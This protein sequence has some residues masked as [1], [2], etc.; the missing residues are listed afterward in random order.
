MGNETVLITGATGFVGGR[1]VERLALGTDY[2][3]KA[4]VRTFSGP[5]L[6]RIARLPV[7]LVLADLLDTES[8]IRAARSCDVVVHCAYGS[9][10]GK[11][12]RKEVT[13]SGTENVL[14]AALR[15]GVRKVIHLSSSAV[16]GRA[17]RGPVVDE[18]APFT[19]SHDLYSTSKIEAEKIVWRFQQEHG[20]PVIVFRPTIIYG[21]YG[22]MW[23]TRIVQEIQSGAILVNGGSGAANL[24]YV[25]NLVDAI[26]LAMQKD[27]GDGEAF[28]LVDDEQLSWQDVYKG[29]ADI[30]NACPPLRGLSVQE[31]EAQRKAEKPSAFD[32]WVGGPW[33]IAWEL[34]RYALQPPEARRRIRQIPWMRLVTRLVPERIKDRIRS[35]D[36]GS[37]TALADTPR[38]RSLRLPGKE[39]VELYA[40]QSRFS[41]EKAK[42]ILG[43]TQ[44]V[45]FD[46]AMRLTSSWLRYQRLIP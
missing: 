34:S 21:P 42:K 3:V 1:L 45:P 19:D 36:G 37:R 7:E 23:T 24:V 17:P 29:Y 4:M 8:L 25:D 41:N 38:S 46:E 5:G 20:L 6:A 22:R 28:I 26:L 39:T 2:Q 12:L 30:I 35:G 33:K 13:V 27:T 40:A 11:T 9:S 14:D 10:G 31:I 43:Y 16:H 44:H 15:T 18:S 32:Q